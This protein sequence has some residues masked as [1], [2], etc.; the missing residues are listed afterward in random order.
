VAKN[1]DSVFY[2]Y[3][4]IRQNIVVSFIPMWYVIT[5]FL[6]ASQLRQDDLVLWL[7]LE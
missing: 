1:Y 4:V 5:L 3:E 6:R 7:Y 2:L